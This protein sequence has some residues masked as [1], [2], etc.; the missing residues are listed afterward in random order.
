M[1]EGR[2][3]LAITVA[4]FF[5]ENRDLWFVLGFE[6]RCRCWFGFK[7]DD[8]GWTFAVEDMLPLLIGTLRIHLK[9]LDLIGG[10]FP[11][12]TK[13]PY[14]RFKNPPGIIGQKNLL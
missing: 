14:V 13:N 10:L 5:P 12:F 4:S 11:P 3:H 2:G 6:K 7:R 8:I 9:A 1:V